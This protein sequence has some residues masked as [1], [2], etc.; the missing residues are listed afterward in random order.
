MA[1]HSVFYVTRQMAARTVFVML[2][3]G[4][5]E[6]ADRWLAPKQVTHMSDDQ[7][8][9]QTD[10]ERLEYALASAKPRFAP[11]GTRWYAENTREPIRDETLREGLIRLGAAVVRSGLPTT[12]SLPRYALRADFAALFDPSLPDQTLVEQIDAWQAKHL[13]AGALA[14]IQILRRGAVTVAGT[15]EELCQGPVV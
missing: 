5:V 1:H 13:T 8:L 15:D 11:R 4:A 9:R 7:A 6:G 12:S 2:Y 10:P 14:C 3:I